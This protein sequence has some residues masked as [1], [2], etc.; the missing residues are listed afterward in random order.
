MWHHHNY[1][2][3]AEMRKRYIPVER[4]LDVVDLGKEDIIM[5]VGGGDGHYSLAFA[6]RC[7]KV[8]YVDPSERA[9]NMMKSRNG[10]SPGNIEILQ[11]DVCN[12]ELPEGVNKVF[13]STS[14][15]DIHC[16]EEVIER[17]SR[18]SGGRVKF[19]LVEF[20][21][22]ADIGPP[23]FV[24]IGPDELDKIFSKSGFKLVRREFFEK[25]YVAM[26]SM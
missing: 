25:H 17:F 26:Y 1:E 23:D 2:A 12:M 19:V 9:V 4:V 13:F 16:R 7:R 8:I 20:K 5:D 21:K 6:D 3:A 15:H 14:F 24:K 22:D 10:D 11:A 18:N